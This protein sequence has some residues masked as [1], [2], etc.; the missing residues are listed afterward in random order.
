MIQKHLN[1]SIKNIGQVVGINNE[2]IVVSFQGGKR[3][4]K[5]V[6]RY[7]LLSSHVRRRTFITLSIKK[8]IPIIQSITGHKDLK[9]FQKYI[10]LNNQA[11][12][13]AM[14]VW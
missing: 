5:V 1:E 6:P 3:T 7:E 9:S 11:K 12:L 2:E 10:K 14:S 8:G 13:D 4:E